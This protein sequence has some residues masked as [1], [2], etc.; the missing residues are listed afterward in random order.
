MWDRLSGLPGGRWLFNRLLGLMVPYTGALGA[1]VE[2][3]RPGFARVQLTERRGVRN[4]LDSVHA[5]ALVN[6]GEITSGLAMSTLLPS[7]VRGIVTNLATDFTKKARGR[8]V[9]ECSCELP[10]V[11]EQTDLQVTAVVSDAEG[12]VVSRTTATWRLTPI[13]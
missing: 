6:L 12:D 10:D 1:S 8:L 13:S 2:E 5:V 9:A 11:A 4:H 3:L 7:T